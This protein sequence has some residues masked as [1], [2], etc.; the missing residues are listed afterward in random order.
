M[1]EQDWIARYFA[2]LATNPG[3]FALGDDAA[4]FPGG[5]ANWVVTTDTLVEGV[6]FVGNEPAGHIAKKLLRVNLSDLAA[7]GAIPRY[8]TLNVTLPNHVS[9]NW[10]AGFAKGLRDDQARYGVA[11]LGGDTTSGRERIVLSLTAMGEVKT[12]LRKSGANVGDKV[13]VTG[14]IG[15]AMLG[16]R[17]IQDAAAMP[18]LSAD[19]RAAINDAYQLPNPPVVLGA[20]VA[21]Q[22]SAGTDV[23][24]GL[25]LD[26][27]HIA[28]QSGVA[29]VIQRGQLPFS[30]A[31]QQYLAEKPDD[32]QS[33]ASGGDDYQL[34]LCFAPEKEAEMH[35]LA[36]QQGVPFTVIGE[37]LSGEGVRLIDGNGIDV[38][39]KRLGYAHFSGE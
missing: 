6:H 16:L 29:I 22:A 13:A 33:F 30:E 1:G 17:Y 20:L 5:D 2:P 27:H 36:V 23:S 8:Y 38:T 4:I 39:P 7:M 10:L 12:P 18:V 32:W 24:D 34:L 37:V 15:D 11:L 28:Q 35:E 9:E 21:R 31:C 14:T 25:L 3:A 19:A 26:A